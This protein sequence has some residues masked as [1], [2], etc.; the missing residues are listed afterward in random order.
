MFYGEYEHALDD[1]GR[2]TIPSRMRD[3]LAG[4]SISTLMLTRGVLDPCLTLYPPAEWERIE[5][6]IRDLSTVDARARQYRR[7]LF[8]GAVE[9]TPD[10]TGRIL[11]PPLLRDHAGI[12]REVIFA[13]VSGYIELWAKERWQALPG[14]SDESGDSFSAGLRD[15]GL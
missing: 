6:R 4:R 5:T 1:K 8:S 14:L 13:G 11:L 9:V 12:N 3:V 7:Q 2:V 10:R 15:L